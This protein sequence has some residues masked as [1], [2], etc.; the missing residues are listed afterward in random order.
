MLSNA[1]KTEIAR[2]RKSH[3]SVGWSFIFNLHVSES[4]WNLRRWSKSDSRS[5]HPERMAARSGEM[6]SP[7]LIRD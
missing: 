3:P 4:I 7:N 6:F 1:V 2:L 5:E